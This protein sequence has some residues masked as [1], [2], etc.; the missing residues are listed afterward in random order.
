MENQPGQSTPELAPSLINQ[1]QLPPQKSFKANSLMIGGLI[2][3]AVVISSLVGI[4]LGRT[5]LAPKPSTPTVV[6]PTFVLNQS[7]T[8][9]PTAIP[10]QTAAPDQTAGWKTYKND[11]LSFSLKYPESLRLAEAQ[12]CLYLLEL[13]SK[14]SNCAN[15]FIFFDII[16]VQWIQRRRW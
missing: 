6:V 8:A 5:L 1:S 10:T 3:G 7:P 14:S 9:L 4:F 15:F 2:L 16:L 12:Q 13:T 11:K